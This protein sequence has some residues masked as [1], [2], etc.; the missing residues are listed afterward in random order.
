[1]AQAN[2]ITEL[3]GNFKTVYAKD[4]ENLVPDF[5]V[6]QK[7]VEFSSIDK[8]TGNFYAQPVILAQESGFSY[9]GSAHTAA[10]ALNAAV[11][12]QMKEAQVYGSSMILRSQMLYTVLSRASA[13]GPKAFKKASGY[14]V[15]SMNSA[16]RHRLEC[17]ML[18]GQI[19][20]GVVETNTTGA[21]VITAASWSAGIWAGREGTVL[22]AFTSNAASTTQHDTNLVIS[23]VDTDTR[24]ITVTGTSTA[25][26]TGDV[27][28]FKGT[29]TTTGFNEMA[30]L[31]KIVSNTGSLFGI[32][33]AAYSL[34]KGTTVSSFGQPTHGKIQDAVSR[35]VNKGLMDKLTVLVSPKTWAVLNTDQ[36]ALRRYDGD[37]K[38]FSNGA[39][40]L[41]FFAANGELEVRCHP[42]LKDGDILMLPL[43]IV[44]RIGS[45]DVT[46][47]VPGMDEQF[48]TLVSGYDA[49]ELQ[50]M[51]DQ[52]IFLEKPCHAIYCSGVTQI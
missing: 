48:F 33:A 14:L 34:W 46:F 51:T 9:T 50:C 11:A 17:S 41:V 5:A 24:T 3:N 30:G 10:T 4:L 8:E 35:A 15:E 19:G 13:K 12:G 6:L 43:D 47:G 37:N 26:V 36:S 16:T 18:Y 44:Q 22:E 38:K 20:L 45:T 40:S 39:E 32:D 49:V 1:M 27:L 21:L 2:S 7:L 25:V 31:V 29:K 42:L 28:F 23:A 52:A